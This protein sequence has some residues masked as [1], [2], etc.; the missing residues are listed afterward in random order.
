MRN[1]FYN[2]G[3][4]R[5]SSEFLLVFI[6]LRHTFNDYYKPW[7]LAG[8][9]LAQIRS[10]DVQQ[11]NHWWGESKKLAR[12]TGP[13]L[14]AQLTQVLMSVVDTLMA[15]RVSSTDLAAVSVGAVSGCPP[16]Y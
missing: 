2:I 9:Y 13:I 16:H 11:P 3:N 15:G 8:R 4:Y 12:L 14:I 1:F 6:I 5:Q 10:T 7:T